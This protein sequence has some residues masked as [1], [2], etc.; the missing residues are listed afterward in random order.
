MNSASSLKSVDVEKTEVSAKQRHDLMAP[1]CNVKAYTGEVR[2]VGVDLEN[3][4]TQHQASLPESLQAAIRN[5]V[6]N[7]ISVCTKALERAVDSLEQ[8]LKELIL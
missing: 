2:Q 7:D 8:Q 5:I 3:L 4:L 6:S 1:I